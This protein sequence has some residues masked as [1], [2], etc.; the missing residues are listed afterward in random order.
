MSITQNVVFG[1][2][3]P[4]IE[5]TLEDYTVVSVWSKCSH[6][7]IYNRSESN[8]EA[9][10]KEIFFES[11]LDVYTGINHFSFDVCESIEK[12]LR[13]LVDVSLNANYY[14]PSTNMALDGD[15]VTPVNKHMNVVVLAGY[16]TEMQSKLIKETMVFTGF[17]KF[18]YPN[19]CDDQATFR[20]STDSS[21]ALLDVV[22]HFGWRNI[23]MVSVTDT[24]V[25]P[26]HMYFMESL[27]IFNETQRFCI[28]SKVLN[29]TEL[30]P[31]IELRNSYQIDVDWYEKYV[32]DFLLGDGGEKE[33]DSVLIIF[34]EDHFIYNVMWYYNSSG[35]CTVSYTHLTLP[36]ILLV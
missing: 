22:D 8:E 9:F 21:I 35:V 28:Q 4:L 34:G 6:L 27:R 29:L 11:H 36:T 5:Y 18:C 19:E 10:Q 2:S 31:D 33:E 15:D 17:P 7:P 26:Y 12:L 1:S 25:Y 23:K 13:V 3:P 30:Y 14:F 24:I 20:T 16:V 32:V